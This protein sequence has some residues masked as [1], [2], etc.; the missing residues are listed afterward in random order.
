MAVTKWKI[1]SLLF[2]AVNS[3]FAQ[4]G[5]AGVGNASTNVLWLS[6]DNGV[7]SDAGITAATN[8]SNVAQWNDRSGNNRHASHGSVGERPNYQT[9]IVNSQPVIRFTAANGDR[10]LSSAVSTGNAA[11]VWAVVSYSSL[12][13]TNPGIIQASPTGLGFS[14]GAGDKT[15]GM[16]VANSVGNRVWGRAI[17]SNGTQRDISQTTNTSAGTFYSFLNLYDGVSNVT[18]YVNNSAAGNVTYD[19]TLASWSEFGIGRQGTES[20]NGDIAEIIAYNVAVNSAQRI[21][22]NNYLAAKYGLTLSASDLYTMDDG[23]NGNYDFEV[24]GI[25]RINASN[26]HSDARGSGILRVLNASGLADNE[27]FIWGHNNDALSA[28]NTTDIPSGVTA[29]FARTWRVSETGDVGNVDLQFDL[30]GIPDFMTLSSCDVALSLRLLVDTNNNGIFSDQTP[31][32]GA[33]NIGGNVYRFANVGSISDAMRFTI[34]IYNP[35]NSGPGGIANPTM[36]WRADAGI[37]SSGGL[38]SVWS[39]RSGNSNHLTSPGGFEPLTTTSSAMNNQPVVRYSGGQYFSSSFSGPG[40]D[41]LTLMLTA[42]GTSYQS[43]IRFQN[44]G[45]NFVVYPW[46]FGGGRTFISSSDGG[47][48]A[49]IN[50]G[51]A[52]GVNNVG[53]ARYRRNTTNG[54]QTYLNGAVNSQRNSLDNALPSESFFSGRYNPG[55]SEYPTC[56]VGEM[57]VYYSAINDAQLIIAQNYLAAKYNVVLPSNDTYRGDDSGFDFDVAGIGRVNVSNIQNDSRGTGWVR[58]FNPTG[59]GDNEFLTW[60]HDNGTLAVTNT[61]DLPSGIQGRLHR[62]WM[63]SETNS[64]GSGAVNVGDVD[65]QFDLSLLNPSITT[66]DL[67]LVIDHDGDGVFGEGGTLVIGPPTALACSNYLFSNVP[68]TSITNNR[69]FT[70]GTTNVSQTP[71]PVTFK[72]LTAEVFDGATHLRWLTSLEKNNASFTVERSVNGFDFIPVGEVPGAGTTVTENSY[73]FKDAYPPFGRIY[74]RVKQTDFDLKNS[75]SEV[76][77]IE[78][79]NMEMRLVP[80]PNPASGNQIIQLHISNAPEQFD[81]RKSHISVVEPTGRPVA[82][83]TSFNESGEALLGFD[84]AIPNGVYIITIHASDLPTPLFARIIIR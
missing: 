78:N 22:I 65:I 72:S 20:W 83:S 41:N 5:P 50:T 37:T 13:S 57:F 48:G 56:D 70:I 1:T 79:K 7:Y 34:A 46:E 60:G 52:S 3:T 8:G 18:Q 76:I 19:G 62:V 36:W 77:S 29:R 69:R 2:V 32:G 82:F 42:N 24:A 73:Y 61:T 49:G 47:T 28:N 23:G 16:W 68:G 45:G 10:I 40:T 64:A 38:I 27:F 58:I 30:S 44:S 15:I 66:S 21:I 74:Y 43:L 26:I 11:S 51:L 59:L 81:F 17:Q 39:D 6:S 12:P 80:I 54:M 4:T 71:L 33:T 14:S 35:S 31:I 9:N 67:R 84:V 25:G 63:V 55:A 75:Y 53:G